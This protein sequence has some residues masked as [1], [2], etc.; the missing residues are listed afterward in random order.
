MQR[1]VVIQRAELG[2]IS[3]E[4]AVGLLHVTARHLRRLR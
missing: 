1:E 3:W 4:E 2:E